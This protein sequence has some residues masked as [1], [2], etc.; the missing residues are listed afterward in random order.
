MG[1]INIDLK[2]RNDYYNT[3]SNNFTI[4]LNNKIYIRK[5]IRL[6]SLIIPKTIYLINWT[7]NKFKIWFDD[8]TIKNIIIPFNNYDVDTLL[9]QYKI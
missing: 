3:N 5:S 6:L 1:Y 9:Q 4:N 7:N 2:Y 8:G